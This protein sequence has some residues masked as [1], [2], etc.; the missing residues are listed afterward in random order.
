MIP[1]RACWR[2]RHDLQR[3]LCAG[4]VVADFAFGRCRP[5]SGRNRSEL[6]RA[7]PILEIG[8]IWSTSAKLERSR[9]NYGQSCLAAGIRPTI[10]RTRP[11]S[12]RK[13]PELGPRSAKIGRNW[14]RPCLCTGASLEL[15]ALRPHVDRIAGG[16]QAEQT[17][18]A[19]LAQASPPPRRVPPAALAAS[20]LAT[21]GSAQPE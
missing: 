9:S 5:N 1:R 4:R 7:R 21:A 10:G 20:H 14:P 3:C 2:Q 6:G 19:P 13:R 17:K 12:G 18:G 16:A 11:E 8:P 15:M